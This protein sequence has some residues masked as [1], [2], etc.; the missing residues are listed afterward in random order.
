MESQ[1]D[2]LGDTISKL[3]Q[4]TNKEITDDVDRIEKY[5]EWLIKKTEFVNIERS[6]TSI[7]DKAIPRKI[8]SIRYNRLPSVEKVFLDDYYKED[9]EYYIL[10][11]DYKLILGNARERIA[12]DILL[13][14]GCVCWVEFG[15]NIGS[16]YGGCRP[17]IVIKN[18]KNTLLVIPLTTQKKDDRDYILEV[19]FIHN[20]PK[21][22]RWAMISNLT[23]I[24]V[25]R[26]CFNNGFG[27]V[28]GDIINEIRNRISRII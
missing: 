13:S 20:L 3:I 4:E 26:V 9:G 7:P 25:H 1:L 16:E 5:L 27:M 28:R 19:P 15:F 12:N 2:L 14:R 24:S 21:K 6:P 23:T 8:H 18:F 17:A 10:A 11:C 22:K